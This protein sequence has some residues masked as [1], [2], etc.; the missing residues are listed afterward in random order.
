MTVTPPVFDDGL[1]VRRQTVGAGEQP[2]DVLILHEELAAVPAF[3]ASVRQ[4]I[5]QFATFQHPAFTRARGLGRL[6]KG[7]SRLVVASDRAE[8]V[9]LSRLLSTA[10]QRLIPLEID[11]AFCLLR[12]LVPAV[13]A[14][15]ERGSDSCHGALAPERLVVT[16]T[17]EIVVVEHVF[18]AALE[19]LRFSHERYWKELRVALPFTGGLPRFDRRADVTQ[20][21]T[22]ALALILGRPLGDDEYPARVADIVEAVRAISASGLELLPD[23]VRSWLCR[24][25]QLDARHSYATA[26]EAQLDLEQISV[27]E[28]RARESLAAFLAQYEAMAGPIG[29]P[30]PAPLAAVADE[31]APVAVRPPMTPMA[32]ATAVPTGA[33]PTATPSAAPALGAV[34]AIT[35]VPVSE[36]DDDAVAP[37]SAA[38]ADTSG[39]DGETVDARAAESAVEV[40][41]EPESVFEDVEHD[42]AE[43]GAAGSDAASTHMPFEPFPP[44][45]SM[46]DLSADADSGSTEDAQIEEASP[47]GDRIRW[48]KRLA[49]AAAVLVALATAGVFA[50]RSYLGASTGTLVVN[51]RPSGAEIAVDGERK[52][53]TPLSIEITAGDHVLALTSGGETRTIPVTIAAGAQVAQFIELPAA[54]AVETEGLLQIRTEPAGAT[55][56][57]DGERRGVSPL[58][59]D[60][61]TPGVHVVRLENALGSV[62]EQVTIAAGM[63]ASLVV[64]L[65]GPQGVPVSGWVSVAAPLELQIFE[66]GRLL[67]SSRSERIMMSVGRHQLQL[68][69]EAI[70]YQSSHTVQVSPGRVTPLAIELPKGSMS[71]N[72]L[73]WA[74]VWVDGERMGETP[75]GNI[76]VAAGVHDVLFRHPEL[77]EQRHAVTV[78]LAGPARVSAD[79]RKR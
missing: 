42:D 58:L 67:G 10:E 29:R 16:A 3:E 39:D 22:I 32:A 19:H 27:D 4:R 23:N 63:T 20:I 37:P 11:A 21:G 48:G 66:N 14:L 61:L 12:Q 33:T 5:E 56:S 64:P 13:A 79:L 47:G 43:S 59:I 78:T 72:A 9:R 50:G 35:A 71:L 6:S 52:G 70:A 36:P 26:V 75:L 2:L 8:G 57:V 62:T 65:A 51:T 53:T 34:P 1:G 40:D 60:K 17:G 76:A 68:A 44:R 49:A 24:A 18:G 54:K 31:T 77:G 45:R 38:A 41:A 7:Q 30:A 55:I 25:L 74:E 69:N 46:F 15:H 73:P 28:T